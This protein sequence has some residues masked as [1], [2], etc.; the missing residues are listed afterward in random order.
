MTIDILIENSPHFE[1]LNNSFLVKWWAKEEEFRRTV[2]AICVREG[3]L[4]RIDTEA[5]V[6][7]ENED[8]KMRRGEYVLKT[9]DYL[10][11]LTYTKVDLGAPSPIEPSESCW[12]VDPY[13]PRNLAQQSDPGV[14]ILREMLCRRWRKVLLTRPEDWEKERKYHAE[15]VVPRWK[16]LTAKE[17]RYGR[18]EREDIGLG[19]LA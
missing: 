17:K 14:E 8:K 6:I 12:V 16:G 11:D 3:Y 18:Y 15:V 10:E 2:Q 7:V 9:L 1:S 19:E 4:L 5:G 13:T